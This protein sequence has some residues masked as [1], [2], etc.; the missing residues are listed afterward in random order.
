MVLR[1]CYTSVA[2]HSK[3]TLTNKRKIFNDPIYGFITIPSDFIFEIVQH[4]YFQRLRR[5]KQLGMAELVYPGAF[6]SRFQ[7][8]LGA[9]HLMNEA[10]NTLQSKGL[11]IMEVER[12]AALVAIL[13]HDIGHGPFSHVLEY[14]ILKNVNHEAI[15]ELLME[16]L[17]RQFEGK[18]TLAIEMFKGTYDRSFFHQLISSQLDMDRMDY[19]NRDSFYTGVAEGNIGAER[20]IKMLHV[21]DN[22]L[23]VEEKGL[24]SVENFLVARRLMYWQVYLHKT[25]VCSETMVL[26]IFERVKDLLKEN[27]F[28]DIPKH[29]KVFF[30]RNI[31]REDFLNDSTLLQNF[32]ALDDV[33]IWYAIKT[34]Q[35]HNDTVL[36]NLSQNIINRNLFKIKLEVGLKTEG[37]EANILQN[38]E[39]KKIPKNLQKY[40]YKKGQISNN[41]YAS[42]N[43]NIK[44]LMKNG[45]ILD[46]SEASD[47]PTIKA[48]SNIVKKNYICYANDVYLPSF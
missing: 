45:N 28:V 40:F 9:M 7:H 19:L 39:D 21:V 6:H 30:N 48:M 42:Q 10:L 24:L 14:A 8:A 31:R 23:V 26:K 4:P 5:I 17:N 35:N 37:L 3:N 46:V 27:I 16:D 13:L 22:Q 43:A 32:V 18:L 47:L 36:A 29:L 1:H 20:I 33:D 11:M 44:I 15:S 38:F 41:G 34:W 25:S 12:E 2:K